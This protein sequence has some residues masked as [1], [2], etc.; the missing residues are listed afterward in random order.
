MRRFPGG[1]VDVVEL[2]DVVVGR[3][4]HQPG[5]RWSVDVRP[6]AGTETCEYHHLGVT[7]EGRLRVQM[8]DGTELEIAEGDVFEIPPGH[9]AWVVGDKP[10]VAVDFAGVRAFGR[11]AEHRTPRRVV[12]LL[13]T[14]VVGSTALAAEVG[15]T[16]WRELHGQHNE[17][18]QAAVDRYHGKVVKW[19]GDGMLA[20]FDSAD[21]AARTALSL[22]TRVDELGMKVRQGIHVGEIEVQETD[23]RG[24]AVHASA[25]VMSLAQPDEILVTASVRDLLDGSDFQFTDRGLHELKG[26]AGTRQIYGIEL[27]TT[28]AGAT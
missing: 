2:D 20:M 8:A 23:V 11:P 1:Q 27:R 3:M 28:E 25:R 24:V 21:R 17:R 9:D 14:D 5:W 6:I 7:L 10:W 12:T 18:A 16:R 19:T 13:F 22:R 15:E 4:M 26:L